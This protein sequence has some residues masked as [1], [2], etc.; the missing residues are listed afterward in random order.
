MKRR[1]N[2]GLLVFAVVI[3]AA[4]CTTDLATERVRLDIPGKPAFT[5]KDAPEIILA[6]LWV[7]AG[8]KDV[9][10]SSEISAHW[11]NAL[12][13]EFKGR[14]T[15]KRVTWTNG[16]MLTSAETWIEAGKGSPGALI[17][18]G[19]VSFVAETRKALVASSSGKFEGPWDPPNP[20]AENR[21]F[22]LTLDVVLLKADDGAVAFRK[23]Y[24]DSL[25]TENKKPTAAYALND[26][27]DRIAPK[28]LS[29]L[30]GSPRSLERYLLTK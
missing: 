26:L 1:K 4:G 30:F 18:T 3:A 25:N 16:E 13:R 22:S 21:N 29:A 10:L 2:S 20:W 12:K 7:E 27:L 9:D 28:L 5:A 11:K 14:L 19:K 8:D 17:L 23:E 6:G 24:R 15:E